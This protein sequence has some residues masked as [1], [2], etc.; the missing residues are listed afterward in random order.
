MNIEIKEHIIRHLE[1]EEKKY[2]EKNS[3]T[4]NESFYSEELK[5]NLHKRFI[6]LSSFE[7]WDDWEDTIEFFAIHFS[8]AEREHRAKTVLTIKE[9]KTLKFEINTWL[10]DELVNRIGWDGDEVI[11]YRDRYFKYLKKIGR[12]DKIINETKRST[13]S[14]VNGFGNPNSSTSFYKK[15]LVVGS[16]QSGKTANFN[17]VINTA[18]DVGYK[19][20]IVLSGIMEDLRVQ[21]QTRLEKEV[22]GTIGKG[23]LGKG[24]GE[25][26]PFRDNLLNS[27][28]SIDTD[29]KRNILDVNFNIH[30]NKNI[31]VCKKN[32]SVLKNILLWLSEYTDD[33]DNQIDLP[34]LIIDDEADNASLNNLG[35]KGK[36]YA[37]KTNQEIRAIL[38][39]FSK[40][41]Y[42][43][44][45]ATP[46][47]NILQ[48]RNEKPDFK[49]ELKHRGEITSYT[50]EDNIFP[51]HFIELLYPPS[52][53]V[54][55]KHFFDTKGDDINKISSLIATPIDIDDP[56]F[57]LQ[58]PPRFYKSSDTPTT[59][60]DKGTR[61][62][63][64]E[65]NYP[66][67]EDGIPK[68]LEEAISCYILAIAIKLSRKSELIKTPFFQPHDT[69]LVHI[70]LFALWQNRLKDLVE[71]H[72]NDVTI[73]LSNE[74]L[75]SG[76][77]L[78]FE[79]VWNKHYE[80]I[81]NNI[82]TE[83]PIGYLDQYLV[84]KKF[85]EDILPLLNEAV[86]GIEVM[87][88]NSYTG[89]NLVYN[90]SPKKYIAIGGNRLSR[91]FT[92]EGLTINYF[93]RKTNT[94]DTLMQMG[95][96]FGYR[97]G[98]IDCCKLFTT[99]DNIE[100]FNSVSATMEDLEDRF[101]YLSE[102]PG[103]TPSDYTIW[104]K[105]NP[106]VIKLTRG[107][108]LKGAHTKSLDFSDT[109][110]QSTHFN[111]DK[112]K[113]IDSFNHFTKHVK[114]IEWNKDKKD[115]PSYL[116]YDTDQ[117]GLLD[118]I[119]LP[120]VM[121]NLDIQGLEQYLD[122]CNITGALKKWK[123]GIKLINKGDGETLS[124]EK[125]QLPLD[126]KLIKRSG[127][128]FGNNHKQPDHN[129][130]YLVENNIFKARNSTIITP[131]DFSITLTREAK[132]KVEK[133]F[134]SKNSSKKSVPDK[135]Y[136]DEMDNSTGILMIYL[137]DIEKVFNLD[138][139]RFST[140]ELQK[141]YKNRGLGELKIFLL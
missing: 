118:F 58:L 60:F 42:L 98:Y 106:E 66:N 103:R 6:G 72:V 107:N 119:N 141:Y 19:M 93:L 34:L 13:L 64:K 87:A 7:D 15:G 78:E 33:D 49:L 135:A 46:F 31:I 48:D 21:T 39:L 91:G 1:K 74:K 57:F 41:V 47:A 123:I 50:L 53:Y 70:S 109:V 114:N 120:N 137:M 27:I 96:W 52:N 113:I 61:S 63:K 38:A 126:I 29:F 54:G 22:I 94:A 125:S 101:A 128:S 140:D 10:T 134:K 108:F 127:P 104:V 25:D 40:K 59:S 132:I 86:T 92:L 112:D 117:K 105:N 32:V 26:Y 56:N 99:S 8:I 18:V 100:K 3:N 84:S 81:V 77:W 90:K 28:T 16:V 67:L 115:K 36:E 62:A 9:S 24:V 89:E 102:L 83:L 71:K 82:K 121:L 95:R 124:K 43:G 45:T 131:T 85:K 76:I 97:P 73:Q 35:A 55:I 80:Y 116:Y 69:M 12:S 75:D 88:I 23:G 65:D 2:R 4:L 79:R 51:D 139:D 111:I 30:S 110:Q 20:I 122:A 129:F 17:G 11:T 68:S 136:R 130:R 37:T 44:Y 133:N 14:I 138:N 5:T